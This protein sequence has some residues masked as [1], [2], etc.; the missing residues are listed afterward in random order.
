MTTT[1]TQAPSP[2]SP[3]LSSWSSLGF[4]RN[5]AA[6]RAESWRG[7]KQDV[8]KGHSPSLFLPGP[9]VQRIMAPLPLQGS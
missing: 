8:M 1:H 2:G 7:R 3:A 4:L 5:A 9:L 6:L